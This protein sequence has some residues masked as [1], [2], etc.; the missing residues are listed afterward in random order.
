MSF[1]GF[2]I[3]YFIGASPA[4]FVAFAAKAAVYCLFQRS[5]GA[6][7]VVGVAAVVHLLSTALGVCVSLAILPKQGF[8]WKTVVVAYYLYAAALSAAIEFSCLYPLRGRLRWRRLGTSVAVANAA[9][10]L[11]LA[12][13]GVVLDGPGLL[14]RVE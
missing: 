9:Y 3:P 4:G 2:L 10:Y 7:K 14:G 5:T 13:G 8:G 6:A 11:S 12:I 1:P